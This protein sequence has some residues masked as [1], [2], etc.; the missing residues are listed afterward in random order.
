M[1]GALG[2]G[3]QCLSS[4]RQQQLAAQ[5]FEQRAA[6]LTFE[7]ADLL[8]QRGL[9][10]EEALGGSGKRALADDRDEV[11]ELVEL[12]RWDPPKGNAYRSWRVTQATSTA[13]YRLRSIIAPRWVPG[14]H[15]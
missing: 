3:Q 5:P 1:Q 2:M 9:R 11:A 15:R 13:F 7:L 6:Q 8:T 4:V 14:G 10:D 12:Y